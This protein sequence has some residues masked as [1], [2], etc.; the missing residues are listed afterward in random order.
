MAAVFTEA[1][2]PLELKPFPLPDRLEPGAVLCRV[3]M[4]TICGSDLHTISGRRKEPTPIILGHEIIGVVEALGEGVTCDRNSDALRVGDRVTWTIMASCGECFFCTRGLPQKCEN[5]RK[6]GHT[7]CNEPPYL[8]G[9]YA[10]YIYLFPGTALFKIPDSLADEVATPA[11]CALSTMVNAVE[12]IRI[13]PGDKVLVQGAGSLGLNLIALAAES[14]AGK[15]FVTDVSD[16]RLEL[17][18]R[19]GAHVPVNTAS[20]DARSVIRMIREQ[21]GRHG[22]DVAFEV[23]GDRHAV[24]MALDA[25]R[26]GGRYLIAGLVMPGSDLAVDGNQ[27]TRKCLTIKG[28]HNYAPEHLGSALKILTDRGTKYPFAELVG[29][30]FPLNRINEAVAAAFAGN[31]IRVAVRPGE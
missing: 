2:K 18:K 7:A 20:V 1:G 3:T 15:I 11:N 4:S 8:T 19:F 25:L 10:E 22:V 6:Y 12:T 17:S 24:P 29:A 16:R 27:I 14:G 31:S 28:I 5:L 21:S 13:D 9:G 30:S 26:I 23:C